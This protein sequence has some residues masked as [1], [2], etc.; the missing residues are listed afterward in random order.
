MI[1]K[2]NHTKTLSFFIK[3]AQILL[4]IPIQII[5]IPF[6]L[7]GLAHGLYKEMVNS[8]KLGV[9]FS[10]GQSL[11]YRWIMHYF[12]TRADQMSV[13]FTKKFPCESHFALWTI[14]GALILARRWFGFNTKLSKLVEPGY[15]TFDTT[16][17]RRVIVF[18]EIMEKYIDSVEQIVMP[19][20]GFDLIALKY[21]EGKAIKVFEIDQ[22]NTINIKAETLEKAGISH[23][24]ITFVPVDYSNE[25]WADKLIQAGF[26]KEKKT[27]FIWQSVSLY[28][29]E[30]TVKK[31]LRQMAEL[32]TGGSVV[33]Q[34]FYSQSFASGEISDVVKKN[35]SL[36][37]KMGEPW[38]FGIDMSGEPKAA[39]NEFLTDCGLRMTEYNQFGEK[40]VIEPFYCIVEAEKL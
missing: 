38:I 28:L 11:Q 22:T 37:G 21:T 4:Y 10:A 29:D 5:F 30:D 18:D 6:A 24:C 25:S 9:S 27:M 36:I 39:V 20:A 14:M 17:G 8:K 19:G 2:K 1:T 23:D 7:I 33:V 26:N 13:E 15:E 12:N 31:S 35:S 34:D 32:C 16:A 40:T 3:I